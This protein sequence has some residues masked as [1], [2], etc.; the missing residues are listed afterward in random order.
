MGFFKKLFSADAAKTENRMPINNEDA[1]K[2]NHKVAGVKHYESNIMKLAKKNP[3][4]SYTKKEIVAKKLCCE[5]LYEYTFAPQKTALIPDPTNPHDP[6]AIKVVI[7]GQHVGYIKAG[8]C[9]RILKLINENRIAGIQSKISGGAFQ[10]FVGNGVDMCE[11]GKAYEKGKTD[12]KIE[13]TI[14]EK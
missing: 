12:Y 9:A 6:N 1:K 8:S 11:G 14:F 13:I 4:Y 3:A 10:M 5:Y 7:D 2:Q